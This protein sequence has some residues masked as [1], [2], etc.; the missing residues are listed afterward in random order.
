MRIEQ[1]ARTAHE[2]NRAYCKSIG[3]DSQPSWENAPKWQKDSAMNGVKF[4]L[5][6]NK[7]PEES[8]ESWLKEKEDDGWIFGEVKDAIKK[9]HPCFRPYN[10]LPQEQKAKDFLFSAVIESLKDIIVTSE[11]EWK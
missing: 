7:T 2:V 10:E 5:T 4:H 1:V 8:H 9:T 6:G 11:D 3:D